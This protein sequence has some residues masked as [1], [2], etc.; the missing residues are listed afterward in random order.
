M[1]FSG[2]SHTATSFRLPYGGIILNRLLGFVAAVSTLGLFGCSDHK[3]PD[4]QA[5]QPTANNEHSSP[6]A[7]SRRYELGSNITFD[8]HGNSMQF[9][10][11]GWQQQ[12]ADFVWSKGMSAVLEFDIVPPATEPLMLKAAIQGLVHNPDL[13]FQDVEVYANNVRIAAWQVA[14]KSEFTAPIPATALKSDN[15]LRIEFRI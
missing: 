2:S 6:T 7:G 13:P 15:P 8:Q 9:R 1:M 4:D 3:G 5:I 11:S 12:E 14:D 10:I